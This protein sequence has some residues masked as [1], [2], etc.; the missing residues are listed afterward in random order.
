[1]RSAPK[2]RA[3]SAPYPADLPG[4]DPRLHVCV[5]CSGNI[6]RSPIGEQVLRSAIAEAGL[7]DQVRVSSAGTGDWHIGQG[8][9]QRAVQGA[10]GR[11]I[12]DRS[13]R[14][15]DHPAGPGRRRPG[16]RR[17]PW[18]PAGTAADDARPRQDR[19]AAVV[20]PGRRRRRGARP[21]LRPRLGLRRGAGDDRGGRTGRRRRRSGG[22]STSAGRPTGPAAPRQATAGEQHPRAPRRHRRGQAPSPVGVPGLP[23]LDRHHPCGP[24][25]LGCLFLHPGAVAVR[26]ERRAHRAEQRGRRLDHRAGRAGRRADV[27]HGAAAG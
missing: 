9:N 27:D 7:A 5:V 18:T 23:R 26:P 21:V 16:A 14:P 6:C 13:P 15:A 17:R 8:A 1:M 24:C 3:V 22:C 4:D 2:P 11:R 12:P 25:V 20:R 19:A 10:A